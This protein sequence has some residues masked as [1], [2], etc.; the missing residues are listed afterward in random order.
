MM[1]TPVMSFKANETN[2]NSTAN[3]Q[4]L[5]AT[6]NTPNINPIS[7]NDQDTFQKQNAKQPSF[8]K[9]PWV[10]V[11]LACVGVLGGVAACSGAI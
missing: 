7:K 4:K 10:A 5:E 3:S 9:N 1:I 6:T 8:Q 11:I 2:V